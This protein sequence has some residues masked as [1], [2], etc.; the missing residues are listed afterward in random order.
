VL[1]ARLLW[2]DAVE[3]ARA[4]SK[5]TRDVNEGARDHARALM[6]TPESAKSRDERKTGEMRFAHLKTD[7]RFERMRL[8]ILS[9]ARDE[10]HL[11]AVAPNLKTFAIQIWQFATRRPTIYATLSCVRRRTIASSS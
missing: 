1:I 3:R 4:F 2:V 6:G 10:F 8:R 5:V 9:G 7:H 11:A